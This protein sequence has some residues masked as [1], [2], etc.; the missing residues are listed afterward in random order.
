MDEEL[1]CIGLSVSHAL[2]T[3]DENP[4]ILYR[5]FL[6]KHKMRSARACGISL[7]LL[8]ALLFE[9]LHGAKGKA[10]AHETHNV[11][12]CICTPFH[13]QEKTDSAAYSYM[14]PSA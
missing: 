11:S 7:A 3:V 4:N 10:V 13:D 14:F 2:S 1:P 12:P 9:D 5:A 6:L 8:A